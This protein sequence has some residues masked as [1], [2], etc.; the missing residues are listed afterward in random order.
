VTHLD[1]PGQRMGET[2][3][4]GRFAFVALPVGR[5]HLAAVWS[6]GRQ[7]WDANVRPGE[8][9]RLT[10]VQTADAPLV[11]E[12]AGLGD[13][14]EGDR[15]TLFRALVTSGSDKLGD[16]FFVADN[17]GGAPLRVDAPHLVPPVIMGDKVVVAG[18]LHHTP[19]GTTL[20]ADAVRVVGA[21]MVSPPSP[22]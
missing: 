5:Y 11:T 12:V 2:D 15:V 17:V 3:G 14:P 20:A 1:K 18:T 10:T 7:E 22:Q 9:A 16:Y 13:R 4:N 8:A 19:G 6:G 21:E